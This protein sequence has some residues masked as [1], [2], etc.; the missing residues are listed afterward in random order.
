V[1]NYH[2]CGL[3]SFPD[4]MARFFAGFFIGG[5][6]MTEFADTAIRHMCH[7]PKCRSKLPALVAN[8]REAFWTKGCHGSFYRS[9]CLICKE[10]FERKNGGCKCVNAFGQLKTDDSPLGRP[11]ARFLGPPP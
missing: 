8:L 4:D 9:R 7:N 6:Q 2:R 11:N 3:A 1:T 5:F 10:A